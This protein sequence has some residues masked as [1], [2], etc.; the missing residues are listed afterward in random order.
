[1]Y[2]SLHTT[3]RLSKHPSGGCALR[4]VIN[5][6]LLNKPDEAKSL[7]GGRGISCVIISKVAD[8]PLDA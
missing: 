1:M 3:Y 2:G 8:I 6:W 4:M 5:L 7:E